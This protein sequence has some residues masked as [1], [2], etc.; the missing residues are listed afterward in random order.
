MH[1]VGIPPQ[2]REVCTTRPGNTVKEY[3]DVRWDDTSLLDLSGGTEILATLTFNAQTVW[4]EGARM[5]VGASPSE[6]MTEGMNP[7]LGARQLHARGISGKGVSVAVIDQPL[8]DD[9]PEFAGK[10]EAYHDMGC[11]IGYSMYGPAVLSLLVGSRCGTAPDARVYYVAVP[12][13]RKDASCYA[14]ALRWLIQTNENLPKDR[15]IRVVAVPAAPSGKGSPCKRNTDQWDAACAMA[16]KAG[17]LVLDCTSD[18]GFIGPCQY[19][20]GDREAVREC[21]PGFPGRAAKSHAGQVLVPGSFRTMAEELAKGQ[22]DYMYQGRGQLRWAIPYAAGVLAMGW[23]VNPELTPQQMRDL[24]F[25]SAFLADQGHRIIDP[26]NFIEMVQHAQGLPG[27]PAAETATTQPVEQATA[28]QNRTAWGEDRSIY[29]RFRLATIARHKGLAD[30][31]TSHY[32]AILQ[33]CAGQQQEALHKFLC[34]MYLAEIARDLRN[35]RPLAIQRLQDAMAALE[36]ASADTTQ[37][38]DLRGMLVS[39]KSWPAY[40]LSVLRGQTPAESQPTTQAQR[41]TGGSAFILIMVACPVSLS[42][43]GMTLEQFADSDASRIDRAIATLALGMEAA[44]EEAY[45]AKAERPLVRLAEEGSYFSPFARMLL[46]SAKQKAQESQPE[47]EKAIAN[48]K[49]DN[50]DV[51]SQAIKSLYFP[52]CFANPKAIQAVYEAQKHPDKPVR[53]EAALALAGLQSPSPARPDVTVILEA[54]AE[55]EDPLRIRPSS[56]FKCQNP[57]LVGPEHIPALVARIRQPQD[58]GQ[59][60]WFLLPDDLVPAFLQQTDVAVSELVKLLHDDN[61]ENKARACEIL[62]RMGPSAKKAMPD[63]AKYVECEDANLQGA[64]LAAMQEIDPEETGAILKSMQRQKEVLAEKHLEELTPQIPEALKKLHHP[65][66]AAISQ[67]SE[68]FIK[69]GPSASPMIVAELADPSVRVRRGA[70]RIL[71]EMRWTD[72]DRQRYG[73][74]AA[75]ALMR[76]ARDRDLTVSNHS[77]AALCRVPAE[78]AIP[79]Y[80]GMLDDSSIAPVAA[81]A[82]GALGPVAEDAAAALEKIAS[83]D[84]GYAGSAA[85]KALSAI[86]P[87]RAGM[88]GSP[89]IIEQL[90]STDREAQGNAMASL[91]VNEPVARQAVPLIVKILQENLG[92]DQNL[93][94]NAILTLG[95]LQAPEALPVLVDIAEKGKTQPDLQWYRWRAIEAIGTMGDTAAPAVP[96]LLAVLKDKGDDAMARGIAAEALGQLQVEQAIPILTTIVRQKGEHRDMSYDAIIRSR[97]AKALG[98]MGKKAHSAIPVLEEASN[99]EDQDV[100]TAAA[101]AI[102]TIKQARTGGAESP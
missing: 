3:D 51:A 19:G 13:W 70:A 85:Y 27:R 30:Q 95:R 69:L 74:A 46:D 10:I 72:A 49:S 71:R 78:E 1:L 7:G 98:L 22:C 18:H 93:T 31:A 44:R 94:D 37:H 50:A 73:Q 92:K 16:E 87:A 26:Q 9:H 43:T 33:Q 68:F 66:S 55:P 62:R 12:S 6:V 57:P 80:M 40:E 52:L 28:P 5:P 2:F 15:K 24:L 65:T 39:L 79:I 88:M 4:P 89:E 77:K 17:M 8:Y 41:E 11:E 86:C 45:F 25:Q 21:I 61:T 100:R 48:L 63:L 36:G 99:D 56:V 102:E 91:P 67:A 35:D 20:R 83:T 60:Q 53:Y 64:V 29:A 58:S 82:L 81:Y 14:E 59:D 34:N 54:M 38:E 47:V 32:Q 42:G 97:A 75:L 96:M 90:R 101:K 76:S 84:K 23:Q